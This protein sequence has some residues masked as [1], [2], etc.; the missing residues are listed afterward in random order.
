MARQTRKDKRKGPTS[1]A[2][3]HPEGTIEWGSDGQRWVV[4]KAKNGVPRWVPFHTVDL[5]GWRPLTV[6]VLAENIGKRITVYERQITN[7]WPRGP[8]DFDVTYKFT[9]SGDGER[10][11]NRKR[12]LYPNWLKSR[13][14]KLRKNDIFEVLGEPQSNPNYFESIQVG[15]KPGELAST[16]LMNTEAFV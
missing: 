9:P 1:S 14:F 4:R 16:N 3:E 11:K 8:K 12:T 13:T 2:T 5:F 7:T 6:K 10:I 15:P